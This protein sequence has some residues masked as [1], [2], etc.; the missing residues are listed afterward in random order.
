MRQALRRADIDQ[1]VEGVLDD[2][3]GQAARRV[4]RAGGA[5]ITA[6]RDIDGARRDKNEV[7]EGIFAQQAG[8]RLHALKECLAI[9]ARLHQA[10]ALFLLLQGLGQALT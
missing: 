3:F 10:A 2:R 1:R 5:T 4:V 7:A 8:E 6:L 9:V